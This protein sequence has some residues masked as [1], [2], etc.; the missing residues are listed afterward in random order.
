MVVHDEGDMGSSPVCGTNHF[1]SNSRHHAA[2]RRQAV[3]EETLVLLGF[4]S[5][6]LVSSKGHF[7]T[8]LN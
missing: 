2:S 4:F 6:I 3:S 1:S 5:G 8:L 7:I